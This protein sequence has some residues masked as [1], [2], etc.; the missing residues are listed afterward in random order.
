M[1]PRT[2]S[3]SI[4]ELLPSSAKNYEFKFVGEGASNI[5][6]EVVVDLAEGRSNILRGMLFPP[7]PGILQ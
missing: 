4:P 5:V 7:A 2:S 3:P 6:F 1:S